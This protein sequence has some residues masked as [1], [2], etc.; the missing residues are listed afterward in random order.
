MANVKVVLNRSGVRSLLQ[1]S[2][3]KRELE[4]QAKNI[5]SRVGQDC[6]VYVAPTRAVAEVHTGSGKNN[7][8]LKAMGGNG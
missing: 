8:L 6:K 1:S 4:K 7:K 2:E 3:M 5:A